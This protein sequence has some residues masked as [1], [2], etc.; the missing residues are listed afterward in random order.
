MTTPTN[1]GQVPPPSP[2][3]SYVFQGPPRIAIRTRT[4]DQ[5][6]YVDTSSNIWTWYDGGIAMSINWSELNLNPEF[7]EIA[8]SFVAHALEKY[9]PV[10][11]LKMTKVLHLLAQSQIALKF[12]WV[13]QEVVETVSAW[14]Q[15]REGLIFFRTLYRWAIDRGIFGFSR[16]TYLA[17]KQI[18]SNHIDPYARI[19]LSQS[20]LELDEEVRLLKRIELNATAADWKDLQLNIILQLGFE[21]APRN[22]QFHSLNIADFE[23]INTSSLDKYY[24]LW[25][26]MA[27]KV[28]QRRPERRPRKV[29][30]SLGAKIENHIAELKRRFGDTCEALFVSPHGKRLSVL[31]IGENLKC[32][33]REAGIERPNQVSTLLRHHLGQGLADQGT[34]AELICRTTRPQQYSSCACLCCGDS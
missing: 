15:F 3:T 30:S 8:K 16:E 32:E 31:V 28:G 26:P 34:S 5:P 29:T 21:L 14:K 2:S 17:I 11:A 19:F 33:L 27:K 24:T 9:A 23:V 25:L 10:T 6:R 22:I 18:K 20:I 4:D 13:Q 1:R 7:L 12:P